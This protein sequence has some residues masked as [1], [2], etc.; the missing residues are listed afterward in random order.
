VPWTLVKRGPRA[1]IV[2]PI[3]APQQFVRE[4]APER[5]SRQ[6]APDS[7]LTRALKL[8]HHW[9]RCSTTSAWL[10][11]STLPAPKAST[12][13][14]VRRVMRLTLLA[15]QVLERL[16]ADSGAVLERVMRQ[17]WPLGWNDQMRLPGRTESR[18]L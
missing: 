16:A 18:L 1:Q 11:W 10:R 13:T 3:D 5:E 17:P 9:H 7:A 12:W 2:T 8:A 15:P 4:A 6:E 14:Q